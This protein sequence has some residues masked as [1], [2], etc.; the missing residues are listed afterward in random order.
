MVYFS[1]NKSP[2][3]SYLART[4]HEMF[5]LA[6]E[7]HKDAPHYRMAMSAISLL[8]AGIRWLGH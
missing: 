6:L 4:G 3:I 8:P 2:A 7:F 1:L 5:V